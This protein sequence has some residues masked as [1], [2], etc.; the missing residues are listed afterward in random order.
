MSFEIQDEISKELT[1]LFLQKQFDIVE[2]KCRS[3]I[4]F[5]KDNEFVISLLACSLMEQKKFDDSIFYFKKG[6][7]INKKNPETYLNLARIYF[8]KKEIDLSLNY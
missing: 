3:I 4:Q 1:Q 2:L 6:L 7:S 8:I 5:Q